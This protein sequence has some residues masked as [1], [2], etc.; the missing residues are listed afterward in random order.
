MV[1][2]SS[3]NFTL[4][5]LVSLEYHLNRLRTKEDGLFLFG[6]TYSS[7]LPSVP[8]NVY[9]FQPQIRGLIF[10]SDFHFEIY[11]PVL[12]RTI[13]HSYIVQCLE[14]IGSISL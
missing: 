8:S 7:T 4:D 13:S 10:P 1:R 9:Q 12:K 14:E 11:D 5:K 3:Q 2:R 6:G